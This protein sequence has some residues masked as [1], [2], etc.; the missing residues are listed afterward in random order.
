[1]TLPRAA[2]TASAM[3][4]PISAVVENCRPGPGSTLRVS[5]M[6]NTMRM[7]TAPTYTSTWASPTN[8]ASSWRN[9]PASPTN[10][11][12]RHSAQCTR[13]RSVI[14][15]TALTTTSAARMAKAALTRV[16]GVMEYWGIGAL[17]LLHH[18]TT[19]SLDHSVCVQSAY[20]YV[21]LPMPRAV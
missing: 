17:E 18:S 8:C 3:P 11:I 10:A 5:R 4:T 20:R 13:L 21:R 2:K 16:D 15:A 19:P 12:A 1:M 7:A 14:A 9:V 6:A